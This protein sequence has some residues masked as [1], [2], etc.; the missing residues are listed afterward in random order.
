MTH[1]H[2]N[3]KYNIQT[4]DTNHT[5]DGN[6]NMEDTYYAANKNMNG[7][8]TTRRANFSDR[9]VRPL[10]SH[11]P[12]GCRLGFGLF[13]R[14]TEHTRTKLRDER[15]MR[16]LGKDGRRKKKSKRGVKTSNM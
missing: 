7:T 10:D 6:I 3:T 12:R 9:R 8:V 11:L 13:V 4:I 2:T 16:G 5:P 14:N 1:I 15:Q